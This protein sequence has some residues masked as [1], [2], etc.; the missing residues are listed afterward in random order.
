M[1][2]IILNRFEDTQCCENWIEN[3]V[4]HISIL[5]SKA[6]KMMF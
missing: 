3:I 2:F 6:S 5:H 4:V 1:L